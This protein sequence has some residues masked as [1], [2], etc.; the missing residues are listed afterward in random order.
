MARS[1]ATVKTMPQAKVTVGSDCPFSKFPIEESLLLKRVLLAHTEPKELSQTVSMCD[2]VL[3]K[4]SKHFFASNH[5][6]LSISAKLVKA[7]HQQKTTNQS[8]LPQVIRNENLPKKQAL[9][10]PHLLE[11]KIMSSLNR[12][13]NEFG[14]RVE[15]CRS[16]QG[17]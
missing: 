9:G 16:R 10:D 3:P 4:C 15:K 6:K 13:L 14:D 12:Q 17:L 2:T 11:T 5:T 1:A 8:Q 7:K